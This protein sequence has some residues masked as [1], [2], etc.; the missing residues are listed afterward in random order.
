VNVAPQ[1]IIEGEESNLDLMMTLGKMRMDIKSLESEL[2]EVKKSYESKTKENSELNE[3]LKEKLDEMNMLEL[4]KK[5]LE[6][7][8]KENEMQIKLLNELR[9]KDTK[10]H[11]KALSEIDTQL[12][13]KSTDADK[14]LN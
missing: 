11:L 4:R 3:L 13:K 5:Q 7:S 2:D 14:V 12:K 6:K 8:V 9:E 10:Q 1:S